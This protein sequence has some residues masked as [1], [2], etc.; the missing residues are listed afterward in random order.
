MQDNRCSAG[1][2]ECGVWRINKQTSLAPSQNPYTCMLM[3]AQH[4]TGQ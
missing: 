2:G 1:V 3:T 4:T